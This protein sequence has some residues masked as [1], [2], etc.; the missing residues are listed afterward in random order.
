MKI[1]HIGIAV[2][3]LEEGIAFYKKMFPECETEEIEGIYKGQ[4]VVII[5]AENVKIELMAPVSMDSVIGKFTE[6]YGEGVHHIAYQVEDI[7][8]EMV[9]AKAEG[10]RILTEEPYKGAEGFDICFIHPR[11]TN[12]VLTELCQHE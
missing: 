8:G 5:N 3:N 12:G 7:R 1:D 9:R 10:I 6:K 11:D 2:K 4:K